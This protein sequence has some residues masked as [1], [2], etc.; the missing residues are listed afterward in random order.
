[1]NSESKT[2]YPL[3]LPFSWL[4]Y[5]ALLILKSALA[6]IGITDEVKKSNEREVKVNNK[7]K[8]VSGFPPLLLLAILFAF[9][10]GFSAGITAFL[11][12]IE[13]LSFSQ[14]NYI[15]AICIA[16][17]VAGIYTQNDDVT[18]LDKYLFS[19]IFIVAVVVSVIV[20]V[21][22]VDH[23]TLRGMSEIEKIFTM[24]FSPF[25]VFL[26]LFAPLSTSL[27]FIYLLYK[28]T[29][30]QG[31][32]KNFF[33]PA[34]ISL[35]VSLGVMFF[36]NNSEFHQNDSTEVAEKKKVKLSPRSHDMYNSVSY[37]EAKE[38][39]AR[40]DISNKG[41]NIVTLRMISPQGARISIEGEKKYFYGQEIESGTYK[42]IGE[43]EGFKSFEQTML[44]EEGGFYLN[45]RMES[46]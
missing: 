31:F 27:C 1:M 46:Y 21:N 16:G 23:S 20:G 11:N 32:I 29:I 12:A 30:T 14:A 9:L 26:F 28:K 45:V 13:Y 37:R 2:Y 8:T 38:A 33:N 25:A 39:A 7:T 22:I 24:I 34:V 10:M 4:L 43:R 19:S 44:I 35:V 41:T 18:S 5:G 17:F 3:A 6:V 36:L 15:F 42:I 40:D